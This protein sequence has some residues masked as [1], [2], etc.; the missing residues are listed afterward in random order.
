MEET[1]NCSGRTTHTRAQAKK[2]ASDESYQ[3]KGKEVTVRFYV[4]AT[5]T[6]ELCKVNEIL[7]DLVD[8]HHD[9]FAILHA[10]CKEFSDQ[11]QFSLSYYQGH[12]KS[13]TAATKMIFIATS[14]YC[15]TCWCGHSTRADEY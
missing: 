5:F 12:P 1:K 6:N 7:K 13:Q 14:C 2:K 9:I 8:Y 3:Q 4:I 15:F 10:D 11:S